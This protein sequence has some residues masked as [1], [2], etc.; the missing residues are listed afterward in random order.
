MQSVPAGSH[1]SFGGLVGFVASSSAEEEKKE[2]GEKEGGE[3]GRD[4]ESP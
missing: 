1:L 4:K 2:T 3:E